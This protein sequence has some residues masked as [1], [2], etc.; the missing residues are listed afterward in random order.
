[1]ALNDEQQSAVDHH[2]NLLLLAGAGSG[3]TMVLANRSA[4]LLASGPGNLVAVSFTKDSATELGNRIRK[5]APG[6]EKRIYAG[7]FHALASSQFRRAGI[8]FKLINESGQRLYLTKA[9]AKTEEPIELDDMVKI[10]E[11]NKSNMT[12]NTCTGPGAKTIFAYQK[13][14][15]DEDLKDFSDLIVGA[16]EGMQTGRLKPIPMRWLLGD[17]FQD[18]DE[19][20]YA[21][22]RMHHEL[23][24]AEVTLV[25]DDDQSIYAFRHAM[26]YSGM[27]RFAREFGASTL[28]LSRNYRCAPDILNPAARLVSQNQHRAPKRIIPAVLSPGDLSIIRPL[29]RDQESEL[30]V[31]TVHEDPGGWAVLT[32]TNRLLDT[33]ELKLQQAG[34]PYTRLG[35]TGFWDRHEIKRVLGILEGVVAGSRII[36]M[37]DPGRRTVRDPIRAAAVEKA[38]K[39]HQADIRHALHMAL[40]ICN[41]DQHL[42][43]HLLGLIKKQPMSEWASIMEREKASIKEFGVDSG[44]KSIHSATLFISLWHGWCKVAGQD[45]DLML[46]GFSRW[47]ET[48]LPSTAEPSGWAIAALHRVH[49][50]I[51]QRIAYA[52]GKNGADPKDSAKADQNN[53]VLTTMHSAKGL[54]WPKVFVIGVEEGMIPHLDGELE[55]ERRLFYVAMTRA[56]QRLV[57]SSVREGNVSPFIAECGLETFG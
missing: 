41:I 46:S 13:M 42:T 19:A 1:M 16:V 52:T 3:K 35:G 38:M 33:L 7:T 11:K 45:T 17:E 49:G 21:W 53:I 50:T 37:P 57:L 44:V 18:A 27:E 23:T 14:L 48:L 32:R 6:N 56:K 40:D 26:G 29:N 25:G 30:I 10:L 2:G 15:D 51:A 20:Q 43:D 47:L 22:I 28:Y 39:K 8:P 34:L 9:L 4:A 54:E 24:N 5:L 12:H 55:E 31:N 36:A